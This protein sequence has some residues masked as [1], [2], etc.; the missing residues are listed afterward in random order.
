MDHTYQ[1]LMVSIGKA[2][3][4]TIILL[5]QLKWKSEENK[6]TTINR[7]TNAM[8]IARPANVGW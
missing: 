7:D 2:G 4:D 6:V 5:K 3:W 8:V 1:K